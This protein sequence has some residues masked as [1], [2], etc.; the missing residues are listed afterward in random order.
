MNGF[1][2][3][4]DILFNIGNG[5]QLRLS[6]QNGV[7]VRDIDFSRNASKRNAKE[8]MMEKLNWI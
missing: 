3:G 2:Y 7:Q 4:K 1:V 5:D 6:M 8:K